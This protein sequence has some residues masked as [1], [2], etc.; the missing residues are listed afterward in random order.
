MEKHQSTNQH[1]GTYVCPMHCQAGKTYERSG[2]CPVCGMP[3]V[4][5]PELQQLAKYTCPMHP[6]IIL[7][8][9]G[10]CPICGMDLVLLQPTGTEEEEQNYRLL[11]RKLKIAT[12]FT[13][14][15]FLIAMSDMIPGN[16]LHHLLTKKGW[17]GVQF[18]L[19]FPVIFYAARMFFERAWR[20]LLSGKYN[21][22]TLIGIGAGA[23]WVFSV[24]A[25]L[26]PGIFPERFKMHGAVY[27]YFEAATVILT[28]VLLGQMLE[29]RAHARTNTA[30]KE[31]LKLSPDQAI[32]IIGGQEETISID[33]VLPGDLLRVKPGEKIPVDGLLKEGGSL[34]DEAMITGEPLPV[35]KRPGDHVVAGTI[36]GNQTFIMQA[37]KVGADTLL[38]QIVAMVASASRSKAPIQKL[39]DRISGYFVPVVIG[40]ALITALSWSVW[41]P[42]PRYIYAFVNALSVL[43]IACPCALG[44]ATPMSIMVGIGKGAQQGILIKDAES[45]E[46]M[47]RIAVLIVD[48]TGT[49]TEG[50]PSV[51]KIVAMEGAKATAVL[52]YIASLNSA[53]EH[54]LAQATVNYGKEKAVEFLPVE[55]FEA[56]TGKGVTGKINGQTAAL[57]NVKLLAQLKISLP[58]TLGEQAAREQRSGKTVS[59][60][61]YD[62]KTIGFVV[63]SD[64]IKPTSKVA[65]KALQQEGLQVVMLTGDNEHTAGAVAKELGLDGFK[66]QMLPEDKLNE[67]KRLQD[68]GRKVAMAGDGINDAPALSQADIGIAM[69]TG[70]DVAIESASITLVKGDLQGIV[71]AR[72]LSYQ[73]MRNIKENLLFALGY[74]ALGIPVAAG[75]LY[76]FTGLLL[77][78]MIAALAMSLSSVSVIANALRLKKQ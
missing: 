77:S 38:S 30:I 33:Q 37:E 51:E 28:L 64:K 29:A 47:N 16:P 31:L 49:L 78:P 66:G 7:G 54:P 9:P 18:L 71:K 72:R 27:V 69:G 25:L 45:L 36:N 2:N 46:K 41:G 76:P 75:I 63:I 44:L 52:Q 57:G 20:S 56:I 73:V 5:Q 34:V 40:I 13:L 50:K 3:L 74:N 53:S 12:S 19:S 8:L 26:F 65:I 70:T 15:I 6:E 24:I 4:K 17:D 61:A 58:E 60:L 42:E 32:R 48:K 11:V 43:I 1:H 14:P 62:G 21:M 68:Q 22:F 39:A 55:A 67:V 59:F 23:A 35:V 10:A